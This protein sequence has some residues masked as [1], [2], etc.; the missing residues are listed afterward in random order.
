MQPCSP[1]PERSIPRAGFSPDDGPLDAARAAF[2]GLITGPRPLSLDGREFP[3]LPGRVM[4]LDEVRGHLLRRECPQRVRDVVWAYLVRR[5]RQERGSATVACVG[6]AMPA[7][8]AMAARLTGRFAGDPRDIHAA[9]LSGFLAE[10]ATVDL[11]RPRIM[12]R[13]RWAAYRAGHDCLRESLDAPSPSARVVGRTAVPPPSG[14][15]DLVLA[16]AIAAGVI[17]APEAELIGSTRLEETPLAEAAAGRAVTYGAA[18]KVRQRAER[19]LVQYLRDGLDD[20]QPDDTD[21][22]GNIATR[23]HSVTDKGLTDEGDPSVR[24]RRDRRPVSPNG[25]FRGVQVRG[26]DQ[27]RHGPAA[28]EDTPAPEGPPPTETARSSTEP[29]PR[30]SAPRPG[31]SKHLEVSECA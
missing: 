29:T 1:I 14:H 28:A 20:G 23:S 27:D 18:K 9:V 13:L 5:S 17:T 16:R 26:R 12:V 21:P 4:A 31:T 6:V 3:G 30:P 15:P 11:A 2:D 8:T 19:R 10:L 22:V 25:P 24:R 7:L